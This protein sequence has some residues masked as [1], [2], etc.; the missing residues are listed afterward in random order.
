MVLDNVSNKCMNVDVYMYYLYINT[1]IYFI[2][3]SRNRNIYARQ[4]S[5][6]CLTM[7]DD[8]L[9]IPYLLSF[10]N[11]SNNGEAMEDKFFN[12]QVM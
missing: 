3:I 5:H 2:L 4:L 7:Y 11:N 1:E 9:T 8:V 6:E 10:S 12:F